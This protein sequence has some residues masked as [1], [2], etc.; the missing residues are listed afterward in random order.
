MNDRFFRTELLIGQKSLAKLNKSHIAIFGLGGVGSFAVEGLA[1]TGVGNLTIVDFDTVGESNINR[2]V[3]ALSSTIGKE[4]TTAMRERIFEINPQCK[5]FPHPVF[6]AREKIQELLSQNYDLV[7]DAID[8]FNPKITLLVETLKKGI[9]I[10]S[11]MGAASKIDPSRIRVEDIS[12][13]TIC[14]LARRIRKRLKGF[15][16]EKGVTVVFSVEPPIT[17]FKPDSI[18]KNQ[19]EVTLKR[20]R[21]RT[22]QGSI[23]YIPAIFGMTLAGLAVQIIIGFRGATEIPRG[24]GMGKVFCQV[25]D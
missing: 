2:Q 17:A 6:F 18:G 1:R 5:V 4:K 23:S 14:P 11:G 16:I 3:M 10:I 21:P 12:R 20:G 13:T 8:S 7:I 22:V 24:I 19:C 9:P 15:G 25:R